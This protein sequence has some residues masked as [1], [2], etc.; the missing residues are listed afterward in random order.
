MSTGTIQSKKHLYFSYIKKSDIMTTD[1]ILRTT[2]VLP[3]VWW[4]D[5]IVFVWLIAAHGQASDGCCVT[6]QHSPRLYLQYNTSY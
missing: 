2:A 5:E 3:T 4:A 1:N 6:K